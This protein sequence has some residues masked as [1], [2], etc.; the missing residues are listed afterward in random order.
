ML[1]FITTV[2]TTLIGS[3]LWP[4]K[5]EGTATLMLDFDSSNPMNISMMVIPQSLTSIE[6]VNTQLEIIKS[7]RIAEGV[8]DL[9]SLDKAPELI[10]A[11]NE[12]KEGN[13]IFFWRKPSQTSIRTWLAD[14]F[15][16]KYLKVEPARDSRF[17]YIKYYSPDPVFSAV[18]ANA[19]AK[20]YS[21]YNLELKVTPF[22]DAGKWFSEKL[23]DAKGNTDKATEQLR[24]YQQKKGIVAQQGAVNFNQGNVNQGTVY[25]DALQRLDQ[26]NRELATGKAKQY[27]TQ[28]AMKRLQESKGNYESLPEVLSNTFVQGLKV[29]KVKLETQLTE[30]SG[31]AGTKHPQYMR[32]QAMIDTVNSKIK[33]EMQNIVNAI[34]QDNIS[35]NQR[36]SALESAVGGLK[37][38]SIR[39]NLSRYEMDSLSK[40]SETYK[41]VYE[42]VLKKQSE[43]TLQGDINRTNVFLVDAAVPPD[44]KYSPRIV[45]NLAL[46]IFVG[47]F[48]GVGLAFFFDYLDDTVKNADAIERQFGIAVLGTITTTRAKEI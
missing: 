23:K 24:E 9:L 17:L 43:T 5:Y 21:D 15:L 48:L 40:E 45:L 10:T 38:E 12:A 31:K 36:V 30:L 7:R 37:R 27:E 47:L 44:K 32:L 6:Y 13:P 28:V 25:D 42:T 2:L 46:A 35:A 8:V 19:F 1:A 29:E 3:I 34:K 16:S 33:A 14:E 20:S 11:F 22:K 41:Q 26:I 39:T 4:V 18:V